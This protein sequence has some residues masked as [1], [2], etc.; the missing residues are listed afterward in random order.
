M[1]ITLDGYSAGVSGEVDWITPGWSADLAAHVEVLTDRVDRIL[2]GR[3]MTH[4]FIT[5]WNDVI[6][7]PDDPEYG[8]ARKMVYYPKIV[9]TR[10]LDASPWPH[11]TLAKGSLTGEVNHLKAAKGRDLIVYG[12][13]TFV[14]ALMAR[15]LIDEYHLFIHPVVIGAG[16]R[17]FDQFPA[18]KRFQMESAR[19]FE[20]GVVGLVYKPRKT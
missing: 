1:Q 4:E 10:T 6:T 13:V 9:F 17:I 2:M 18:R 5:Y 19:T 11:T 15:D 8:F 3:K 20:N 7:R 16:M 12:G 14:S